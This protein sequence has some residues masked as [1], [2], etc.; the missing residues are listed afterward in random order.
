MRRILTSITLIA[1]AL[2]LPLSAVA[3]GQITADDSIAG[4]GITVT[5]AGL[6][7]GINASILVTNPDSKTTTINAQTDGQGNATVNVPGNASEEAGTYTLSATYNGS[8]IGNVTTVAVLPDTMDPWASQVQS[9]TPTIAADGSDSATITVTMRDKYGNILP[10]RPV[11]L[12]SNRPQDT[13]TQ[14]TPE[15]DKNGAQQFSLTTTMPGSIQV[16]A[17]DLLSGNTLAAVAQLTA[18]HNAPAIGGDAQQ[19]YGSNANAYQASVENVGGRQ[20]YAQAAGSANGG[21]FDV[22]DHFEVTAPTDMQTGQEAQKVVV[23]AVDQNGNTVQ[24]YAGTVTFESTDPQATLP[25]F[26]SYTFQPRDLGQKTFPLVLTFQTAGQQIFRVKDQNNPSITGQATVNVTGGGMHGSAGGIQITSYKDGDTISSTNITIAGIGPAYANLIVIG[27][28]QNV[29]GSTD[30]QGNF[31][32]PITLNPSQHDFTIDVHDDAGHNDSGPLHLILDQNPPTIGA[33]TFAPEQ[34]DADQKTLVVAQADPG[35]ASMIMTIQDSTTNT[36]LTVPLVEIPTSTGS[37]QAFFNAP[38]A[39]VYQPDFKA[40]DKAGNAVDVRTTFTVGQQGL[41]K[42]MNVQAAPRVNAVELTWDPINDTL[43]GYRIYVGDSPNNFLYTLD[44]GR[45]T[46][47]ATIAGLTP[48]KTY[49]F[50]VTALKQGLE[51]KD[52]SDPVQAQALGLTLDVTPGDGTLDLKWPSLSTDAP[53]STFLL[54]YGVQPDTY[55]ETRMLNGQLRDYTMRD[56]LNGVTYYMRLT[57]ITV[58]GDKLTDLAAKGQGTPNGTGF[59]AGPQDPI[60]GNLGSLP[61]NI[62]KPP[63]S[64]PSNGLPSWLWMGAIALGLLGALYGWHRRQAARHNAAFL[65]AIQA[66]YRR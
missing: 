12:V 60:P 4:V 46:T 36:N 61:G 17:V 1:A 21:S 53:L 66:Q 20:F 51:S 14:L 42:V 44:T 49:Y 47:K 33:I 62:Q 5:L 34:P 37:Y 32:I 48:G 59:H 3:Q 57:P 28:T 39:G 52:K 24:D 35:L 45:V 22:I 15:T 63:T 30:A 25:N 7:P 10:G 9:W 64:L 18:G 29:T 26:G 8:A 43:D 65:A 31:S 40:T 50:A 23:R 2:L 41:A 27:G 58:T 56:L 38:T 16:R 54:E 11:A 6:P 13:I 55:T 19:F